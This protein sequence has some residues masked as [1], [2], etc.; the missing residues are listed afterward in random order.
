MVDRHQRFPRRHAQSFCGGQPNQQRTRQP[1]RVRHRNGVQL[2][3]RY[4]RAAQRFIHHRQNPFHVCP[5]RNLRHHS[6]EGLVQLVLRSHHG[7]EHRQWF[8]DNR[9]RRFV[10]RRFQSQ[11][12][13]GVKVTVRGPVR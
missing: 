5:R 3:K 4:T 13:H 6:A 1:G 11:K 10:A 2:V 9:R 12:F 7:R 8:R